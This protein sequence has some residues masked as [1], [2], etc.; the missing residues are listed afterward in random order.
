MRFH[1]RRNAISSRRVNRF[2]VL[3]V[4]TRVTRSSSSYY[5]T[6]WKKIHTGSR[7]A[8]RRSD[9][10]RSYREIK[11]S[12]FDPSI[13][14][15]KKLSRVISFFEFEHVFSQRHVSSACQCFLSNTVSPNGRRNA[16]RFSYKQHEKVPVIIHRQKSCEGDSRSSRYAQRQNVTLPTEPGRVD[17]LSEKREDESRKQLWTNKLLSSVEHQE[18]VAG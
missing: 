7:A 10:A 1:Q 5:A 17:F 3:N 6:S 2:R 14:S 15:V 11:G 12:E 8:K 16:S 18:T 9:G 13:P 4:R